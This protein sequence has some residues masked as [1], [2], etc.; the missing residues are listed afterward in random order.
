MVTK[1]RLLGKVPREAMPRQEREQELRKQLMELKDMEDS[2]RLQL[3][4]VGVSQ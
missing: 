2:R 3:K 1:M 4:D